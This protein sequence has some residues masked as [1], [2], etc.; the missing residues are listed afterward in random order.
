MVTLMVTLMNL[1]DLLHTD[2]FTLKRVSSTNGGEYAGACPWCGG[3]DRFR[4]WPEK[5]R[6]WCRGCGKHGDGIQYLRDYRG[7]SYFEAL[8]A[9]G[10]EPDLK[11]KPSTPILTKPAPAEPTAPAEAWQERAGKLQKA[12]VECLW[13]DQGAPM[14]SWLSSEKGLQDEIIRKAGLGYIQRTVFDSMANWGL[15]EELNNK[16]NPKKIWLPQGILIPSLQGEKIQ[17]LKIRREHLPS[18]DVD[19][20]IFVSGGIAAPMILG[21]HS[22]AAAVIV[23]SELDAILLNQECGD[24]V[25]SI[26]MGSAQAKSDKTTHELLKEVLL[27]LLALD[28]DDAGGKASW[29]FWPET[30][31]TKVK[32]WPIPSKFGKDP[33]EAWQKGM[34]LIDWTLAGMF[35]STEAFERFSIM[36]VDGGLTDHEALNAMGI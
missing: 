11:R 36:T 7:L 13:S 20:Y 16:G 9:L 25:V 33:S 27:I 17:R 23:E 5:G 32:R 3:R 29:T 14:R 28:T 12:A 26:A 34:S 35:K 22:K 10:R 21:D 30:Y 31:G 8:H 4:I 18:G 6:Y 24:L 19:R 1:L 15:Q 2:G